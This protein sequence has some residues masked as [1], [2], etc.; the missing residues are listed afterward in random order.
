MTTKHSPH[1]ALSEADASAII[2][3]AWQDDTPFEA[4]AQQ[5]GLQEPEVIALM[6]TALKARSFRIWRMR[7]RGRTAK[8]QTRQQSEHRVQSHE[9][10]DATLTQ[11]LSEAQEAFPLP[12][13]PLTPQS[14][15]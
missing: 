15:R 9:A 11:A 10:S 13:S 12:P 8:H 4:I 3:M 7:V 5:F 1:T 2:A 6:R 14:L